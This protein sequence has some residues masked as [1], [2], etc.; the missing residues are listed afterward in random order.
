[1]AAA[2]GAIGLIAVWAG[3]MSERIPFERLVRFFQEP[4]LR[5]LDANGVPN[6]SVPEIRATAVVSEKGG[7]ILFQGARTTLKQAL[8]DASQNKP[9]GFSLVGDAAIHLSTR[10][11]AATSPNIAAILPGSDPALK[12][13]YVVFSAHLDHLGI[14]EA[15]KGDVIY[16]GAVDNASGSFGAAGNSPRLQ[17]NAH[18]AAPIDFIFVGDRRRGRIAWLRLFCA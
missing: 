17:R 14:G 8:D 10:Y 9:Q 13:E 2:H 11:T 3:P 12:N 4:Q 7:E 6:E 16:N 15:I 5:W 1:M 18:P